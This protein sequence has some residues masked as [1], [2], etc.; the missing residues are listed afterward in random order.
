MLLLEQNILLSAPSGDAVLKIADFSLS[1][2]SAANYWSIPY[3]NSQYFVQLIVYFQKE[4]LHVLLLLSNRVVHPGEFAESVCGTPF[5]MA[6]E[7]MEFQ[8]Y[9]NKVKVSLSSYSNDSKLKCSLYA[10]RYVEHWCN[11]L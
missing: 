5:Y 1:R 11:S 3:Q 2:Y 8:K 4:F 7:V 6:P 10:G 9:D